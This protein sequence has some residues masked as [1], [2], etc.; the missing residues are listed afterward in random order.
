MA[1]EGFLQRDTDQLLIKAEQEALGKPLQVTENETRHIYSGN[2]RTENNFQLQEL[3]VRID[4]I[5]SDMTTNAAENSK[6]LKDNSE[7]LTRLETIIVNESVVNDINIIL[8]TYN[9]TLKN[10]CV[11]LIDTVVTNEASIDKQNESL[12]KLESGI[13]LH[14]TRLAKLEESINKQNETIGRQETD[15]EFHE[16]KQNKTV[17]K[18]YADIEFHETRLAKLETSIEKQNATLGKIEVD[19]EFHENRLAQLE[20]NFIMENVTLETHSQNIAKLRSD[21]LHNNEIITNLTFRVLR[22][23][24]AIEKQSS[25][26][27]LENGLIQLGSDINRT[28]A[29]VK[30]NSNKIR[31]FEE[32]ITAEMAFSKNQST[33]MNQLESDVKSI[34]DI[35]KDYNETVEKLKVNRILIGHRH[36]THIIMTVNMRHI[37]CA[38]KYK[39]INQCKNNKFLVS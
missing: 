30:D 19:I 10:S 29:D 16:T 37:Q 23:E 8:G 11:T 20:T 31:L 14:E 5:E 2:N 21:Q 25:C 27:E 7:R 13:D 26:E 17:S 38:K 15:I 4:T 35:V 18:L 33:R 1:V 22:L 39:M 32:N 9:E 24:A 34:Q 12:S 28:Q 6:E 36:H 3:I